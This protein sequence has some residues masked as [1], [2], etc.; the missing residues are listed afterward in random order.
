MIKY[1]YYFTDSHHFQLINGRV[2]LFTKNTVFSIRN[3]T[4]SDIILIL[5]TLYNNKNHEV[6][7]AIDLDKE[8]YQLNSPTTTDRFSLYTIHARGGQ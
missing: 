3:S 7:Q 4:F 6:N 5:F 2:Y 8:T 1:V